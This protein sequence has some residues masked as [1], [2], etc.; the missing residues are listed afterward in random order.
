MFEKFFKNDSQEENSENDSIREEKH[1]F[2]TMLNACTENIFVCDATHE[3]TLYWMNET[4]K[5]SLEDMKSNLKNEMGVDAD[6][7]MGGSIHRYHKDPD[8]IRNILRD[9]AAT[10]KTHKMDIPLGRYVLQTQVRPLKSTTGELTGFVACWKDVSAERR[11]REKAR[12]EEKAVTRIS[13]AVEELTV[14]VHHNADNAKAANGLSVDA[15]DIAEN[16]GSVAEELVSAMTEISKSSKKI[17]DITT[18][19]DEIAFQTNLLSLN[20]A[21]EAARAGELGRG[22][23]V[24]ASEVRNLAHRSSTAAKEITDL[25]KDSVEKAAKGDKMAVKT[26]E[27]LGDIV[28]SVKKVADLIS[29]ISAASSEQARGID[30]VNK[31]ILQ[32]TDTIDG[33]DAGPQEYSQPHA[34]RGGSS[35]NLAL[36]HSG[37][38]EEGY[39]EI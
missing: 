20:A 12:N 31:S 11:L 13:S 14:S 37:D 23:A 24:V 29:E 28:G 6:T 27:T 15:R 33:S 16:G 34:R 25:I 26:G 3:N 18:V 5:S 38:D 32:L 35:G 2:E 36:A 7:I 30:E 19:I 10:D 21:I 9:M 22:F 8:A 17:S 1:K 4:A 39:V